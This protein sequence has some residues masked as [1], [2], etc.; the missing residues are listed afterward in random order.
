[1]IY[2]QYKITGAVS[3]NVTSFTGIGIAPDVESLHPLAFG[4]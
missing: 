3:A 2:A 4:I 1:M